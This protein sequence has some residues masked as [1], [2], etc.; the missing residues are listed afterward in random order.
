MKI[1][2]EQKRIVDIALKAGNI[3]LTNGAETYRVE[4]TVQRMM[5]S[6]GLEDVHV[7]VIPTGIIVSANIDN[8]PTTILER[9][10]GEG[11]DLEVIDRINALSRQFTST[12]MPIEAASDAIDLLVNHPPAFSKWTRFFFSGMAGGFFIFLFKGSFVEF[13]LAYIVSS[14][15]VLCFDSLSDKRLNFFVKNII[16]GFLASLFGIISVSLIGCFGIYA[17]L[18]MVIIGP[19]MTLVPGVSLNNGIRDLISGELL[20]GSA[21]IT[22]AL[23]IAIAL[24]FGVGIMLQ[25]G[26]N[27]I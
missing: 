3:M 23:F 11:I 1:Q 7:F 14:F 18:N 25:L 20:A 6:R 5:A 10:H 8:H 9:V 21:K 16:G 13:L 26:I 12:D 15:T 2:T 4:D 24:A 19:L 27:F 17:S 22:E